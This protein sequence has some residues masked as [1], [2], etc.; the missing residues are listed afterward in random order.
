MSGAAQLVAWG[1]RTML[2]PMISA[3]TAYSRL[4]RS[5]PTLR[6]ERELSG[7]YALRVVRLAEEEVPDAELLGL[8]LQLE[9][10]RRDRLPSLG[11]VGRDLSLVER[12]SGQALLLRRRQTGERGD[13]RTSTKSTTFVSVSLANGENL[14]SIMCHVAAGMKRV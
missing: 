5:T 12:L 2:W 8:L 11:R 3:M 14:S 9:E 4:V 7:W 1:A 6:N 13:E 10:D